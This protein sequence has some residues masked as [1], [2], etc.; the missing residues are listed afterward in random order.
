MFRPKAL[1]PQAAATLQTQE[2]D[3]VIATPSAL[4]KGQSPVPKLAGDQVFASLFNRVGTKSLTVPGE[5]QV[6]SVGEL[7]VPPPVSDGPEGTGE[8][9]SE[10]G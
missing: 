3:Q 10:G 6:H 7:F 1:L 2:V 4:R 9:G 8:E 5:V